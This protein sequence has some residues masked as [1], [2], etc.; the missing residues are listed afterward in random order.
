MGNPVFVPAWPQPTPHP[1]KDLADKMQG[2][3]EKHIV[4]VF[5]EMKIKNDLVYNKH[6]SQIIGYVSLGSMEQQLLLLEEEQIGV[7]SHVA[8]HMLQSMVQAISAHLNYPVAHFATSTCTAE[9]LYAMVWDVIARLESIKMKV[10]IVTADG[11]S[12]NR[13]CFSHARRSCRRYCG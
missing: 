13:K 10:I 6:T 3:D 7:A 12:V 9:Q 1:Y 2:N 11:A 5:D 4:L 8:T